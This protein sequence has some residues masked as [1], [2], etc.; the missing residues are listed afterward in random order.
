MEFIDIAVKIASLSECYYKHGAVLIKNGNIICTGYNDFRKHAEIKAINKIYPNKVRRYF[1][2]CDLIVV[3][4]TL[5]NSKPC[6]HCLKELK[7]YGIRRVYYSYNKN[8][9]MEKVSEMKTEYIT[10]KYRKSWLNNI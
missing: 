6:K 9:L 5:S 2:K 8:L 7:K 3:R 4:N 10:S 1:K